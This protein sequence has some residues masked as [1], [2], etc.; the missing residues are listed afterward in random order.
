MCDAHV[1]QPYIQE[2]RS[3]IHFLAVEWEGFERGEERERLT[4]A[5]PAGKGGRIL[6]AVGRLSNLY[7]FTGEGVPIDPN[8][9]ILSCFKLVDCCSTIVV[10][11][12]GLQETTFSTHLFLS[13]ISACSSSIGVGF[14]DFGLATLPTS[15]VIPT[16][17][18]LAACSMSASPLGPVAWKKSNFEQS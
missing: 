14:E 4:F 10:L 9:R 17:G 11:V 18:L 7:L 15:V 2:Q 16:L 5:N 13:V 1:L 12:F 3:F 6:N 8:G